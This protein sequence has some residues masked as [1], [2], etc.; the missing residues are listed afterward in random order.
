M[1]ASFL[2]LTR[3]SCLGARGTCPSFHQHPRSLHSHPTT[4]EGR[5]CEFFLSKCVPCH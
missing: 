5:C 3:R 4:Y 2:L 1:D